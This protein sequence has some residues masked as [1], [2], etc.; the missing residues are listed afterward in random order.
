MKQLMALLRASAGAAFFFFFGVHPMNTAPTII[1]P[2][3]LSVFA[4]TAIKEHEAVT[5]GLKYALQ[6]A[7]AAGDALIQA[8]TGLRHGQWL[9]WLE[10]HC[11]DISERSARNY[12]T[13]AA[14]RGTVLAAKSATLA[15]LSVRGALGLIKQANRSP[16]S[17]RPRSR[18]QQSRKV[19]APTISRHDVVGWWSSAP[20]VERQRFIDGVGARALV[21]A[22]PAHWNM[23]LATTEADLGD[24]DKARTVQTE[25]HPAPNIDDL[26]IPP[27]LRR[28]PA[29]IP[30]AAN[31]MPSAAATRSPDGGS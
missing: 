27:C 16:R 24:V 2:D 30:F 23:T 21:A 25:A 26:D 20:V 14:A 18:S 6:H 17:S 28:A 31:G 29:G 22:I 8:K 7:M 10:R 15:D 12:M 19:S 11:A 4:A 3:D 1:P 9:P 13:I 5:T